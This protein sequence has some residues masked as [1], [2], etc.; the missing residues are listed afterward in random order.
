[1][2]KRSR[3]IVVRTAGTLARSYKR[4]YGGGKYR[5][6][7]RAIQYGW[8]NRKRIAKS[9]KRIKRI[10]KNSV[11]AYREARIDATHIQQEELD[12]KPDQLKVFEPLINI[13]KSGTVEASGKP[14]DGVRLA[15]QITLNGF[16]IHYCMRLKQ[17]PPGEQIRTDDC[18]LRL[19]L[20]E[21]KFG[22]DKD[23]AET[24]N[25][26]SGLGGIIPSNDYVASNKAA[27]DFKRVT[28]ICT[29]YVQPIN[30]RRYKV[31]WQKKI[32]LHQNY[33]TD[34]SRVGKWWI[35]YKKTVKFQSM[36]DT[37]SSK[38]TEPQVKFLYFYET[39]KGETDVPLLELD[40]K[41]LT[42]FKDK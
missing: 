41:W 31:L 26:F 39:S 19:I 36:G 20:V 35:P 7:A 5:M 18:Y 9:A 1:M 34:T 11:E 25:I 21:D 8:R 6:A 23:L 4:S 13:D 38:F 2:P 10:V 16:R 37:A 29:K 27:L 28:P 24:E 14:S 30:S 17:L 12:F 33:L 32:K 15:Q 42:Y 3:S 40:M 22:R